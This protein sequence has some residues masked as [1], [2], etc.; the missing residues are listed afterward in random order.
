[1]N[2]NQII[3][4]TPYDHQR[5]R[6]VV[7]A[8]AAKATGWTRESLARLRGELDRAMVVDEAALPPGVVAMNSHV[9]IVDLESNETEQYTLTFPEQA[10][11]SQHRL[12][13]L[14][15]IGTAILGYAEGDEV[16]WAT[17]GGLRKLKIVS[18]RRAPGN[19]TERIAS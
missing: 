15:P 12:S 16:E 8:A 2:P 19:S 10:D 17:P 18:V 11:T 4:M 6:L 3:Y 7:E 5:L 13:V 14:A 9:T 1:M